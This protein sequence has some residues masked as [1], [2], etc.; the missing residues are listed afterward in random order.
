MI[1]LLQKRDFKIHY[2]ILF[3]SAIPGYYGL[4]FQHLGSDWIASNGQGVGV[5]VSDS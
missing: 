1:Y 2:V 5:W 4:L 3:R